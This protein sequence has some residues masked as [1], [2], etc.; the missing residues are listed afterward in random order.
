M[1]S[2]FSVPYQVG[3][4]GALMFESK[5][6]LGE[7]VPIFDG[8]VSG[9][10]D[11]YG[12]EG[13]GKPMKIAVENFDGKIYRVVT[14]VGLGAYL[15]AANSLQEIGLKD[16]LA[17]SIDGK[18]G[19][20][21]WFVSTPEMVNNFEPEPEVF[22]DPAS[23][24]L[25]E[26]EVLGMLPETERQSLVLSRVGQGVFR[27]Q[28]ISFWKGCAV[29]GANCIPLLKASHIK[30]WRNSNNKERLDLFNGLL[31]S[32]NLDSA[33]DTGLITFDSNGKIVL[34]NEISGAPAFQLHINA[35]LRINPKL[36][37][38]EHRLYLEYHRNEVFRG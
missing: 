3:H 9:A 21:S 2:H 23:E 30:P 26:L 27:A 5:Y 33:F 1:V 8:A 34:S 38:I 12:I 20:D 16:L 17:E 22:Y 15:H 35:K 11:S 4:Q 7:V 18:E 36:F 14:S 28:L 29:T 37:Q 10:L 6:I 19:Y 25:R 13:G 31:L 24:I 32:P